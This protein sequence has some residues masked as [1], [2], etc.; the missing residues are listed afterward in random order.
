MWGKK[1]TAEESE[2]E[3]ANEGERENTHIVLRWQRRKC[4]NAEEDGKF[5]GTWSMKITSL[6]S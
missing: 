2:R 5:I 4:G 6:K 3:R 1:K